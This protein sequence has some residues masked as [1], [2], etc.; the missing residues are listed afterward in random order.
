MCTAT[1]HSYGVGLENFIYKTVPLASWPSSL[2][3]LYP[4]R[5]GW[6][7]HERFPRRPTARINELSSFQKLYILSTPR[8]LLYNHREIAFRLLRGRTQSVNYTS[9]VDIISSLMRLLLNDSLRLVN[10]VFDLWLRTQGSIVHRSPI[11]VLKGSPAILTAID[12][13]IVQLYKVQDSTLHIY[14]VKIH[15]NSENVKISFSRS[16]GKH[17]PRSQ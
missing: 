1:F 2:G 4:S 8:L 9:S 7:G 12:Y 3:Y 15:P 6:W 10:S 17:I 11:S 14:E 13:P 16:T 5:Q